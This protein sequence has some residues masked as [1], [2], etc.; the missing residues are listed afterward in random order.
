MIENRSVPANIMIAHIHYHDVLEAVA[1]LGKAFGFEEHFRYGDPAAPGGSQVHLGDVWLMIRRAAA[2]EKTPT[3]L[4]FGTQSLTIFVEDVEG[5]FARAKA[6]GA[7]VTEE[8]HE[9]EYG[10]FQFAVLDYEGHH[11]IFARHARDADPTSWGATVVNPFD[12]TSR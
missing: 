10:E 2:D 4:G 11:W 7:Q 12:R 6:A 9:T 1:W 8:P 3:E 5:C